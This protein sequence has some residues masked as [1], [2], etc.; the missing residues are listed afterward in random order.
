[1]LFTRAQIRIDGSWY[2]LVRAA[3]C[4]ALKSSLL[5]EAVETF[6]TTVITGMV[7]ESMA[8]SETVQTVVGLGAVVADIALGS[9]TSLDTVSNTVETVVGLR[10]DVTDVAL[11]W[12][13]AI[14][15]VRIL[16]ELGMVINDMRLESVV[17]IDA[18][19]TLVEAVM[20]VIEVCLSGEDRGFAKDANVRVLRGVWEYV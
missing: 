16:L 19:Q 2:G 12:V 4:G 13:V 9:M 10:A 6:A 7:L 8:S 14:E 5:S 1:M 15:A 11:E 3:P 20:G 18:I 17:L